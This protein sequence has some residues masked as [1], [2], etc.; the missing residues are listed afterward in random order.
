MMIYFVNLFGHQFGRIFAENLSNY[1]S[2]SIYK[3]LLVL[4]LLTDFD[5]D[6]VY[7]LSN[8]LHTFP[9]GSMEKSIIDND[10]NRINK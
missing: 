4:L 8:I 9:L 7:L 3:V 10:V 5:F 2:D 1:F 6:K